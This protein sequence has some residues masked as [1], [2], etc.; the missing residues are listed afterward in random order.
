MPHWIDSYKP[1]SFVPGF[2]VV[3]VSEEE[4][5]ILHIEYDGD[6]SDNSSQGEGH[7]VVHWQGWY[8]QYI[9]Q[10]Y[11]HHFIF[12]YLLLLFIDKRLE[13]I[14]KSPVLCYRQCS[15]EQIINNY[16]GR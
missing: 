7:Y 4:D 11:T 6:E 3:K 13:I 15:F 2:P 9:Q 5:D 1:F 16:F 10:S 14:M 8:Q 12:I